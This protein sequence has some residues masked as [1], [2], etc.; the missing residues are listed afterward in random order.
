MYPCAKFETLDGR[1]WSAIP[2]KDFGYSRAMSAEFNSPYPL[3]SISATGQAASDS[4]NLVKPCISEL[5]RE[6]GNVDNCLDSHAHAD[7]SGFE[8]AS[9][10]LFNS[11][12]DLS[13]ESETQ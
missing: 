11:F 12:C 2:L 4:Q 9:W 10:K 7:E 8:S 3:L 5:V 1:R 6:S 13:G